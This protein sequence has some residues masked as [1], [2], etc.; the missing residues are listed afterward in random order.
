MDHFLV[1]QAVVAFGIDDVMQRGD[2]QNVCK[3]VSNALRPVSSSRRLEFVVGKY[4]HHYFSGQGDAD[5]PRVQEPGL[6]P[7]GQRRTALFMA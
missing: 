4:H 3:M 6:L 2:L 5:H 1:T 7:L